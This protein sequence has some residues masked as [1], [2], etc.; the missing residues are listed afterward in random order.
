MAV[1]KCFGVSGSETRLCLYLEKGEIS[2]S[3]T[4]LHPSRRTVTM[5]QYET[6]TLAKQLYAESVEPEREKYPCHVAT[7]DLTSSEIKIVMLNKD[8]CELIYKEK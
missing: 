7:I 4:L 8:K 3:V 5:D 1:S 6:E 2:P